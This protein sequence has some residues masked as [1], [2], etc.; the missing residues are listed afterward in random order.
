MILLICKKGNFLC[1]KWSTNISF[2]ALIIIEDD[3]NGFPNDVLSKIG[4]PYLKSFKE[5]KKDKIGLGLGLFIGKTLLEKNFASIRCRNSKIRSGA[6]IIISWKN[7]E[8]FKI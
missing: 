1:R 5:T 7:E 6:E 3:G 4:E 2:D 8:L